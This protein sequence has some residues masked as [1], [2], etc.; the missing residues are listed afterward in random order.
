MRGVFAWCTPGSP[1]GATTSS[2]HTP[3][4]GRGPTT[5]KIA[6]RT[7]HHVRVGT[8]HKVGSKR[9]HH[10]IRRLW[11]IIAPQMHSLLGMCSQMRRKVVRATERLVTAGIIAH[12]RTL[13]GMHQH[14]SLQVLKPFEAPSTGWKLAR[15]LV[16]LCSTAVI[17]VVHGRYTGLTGIGGNRIVAMLHIAAI[18]A[19]V[20]HGHGACVGG[21]AHHHHRWILNAMET[22]ARATIVT[23]V[24][25]LLLQVL[26]V[27]SLMVHV[28]HMVVVVAVHIGAVF[29][30]AKWM[31]GS[32]DRRMMVMLMSIGRSTSKVRRVGFVVM[33]MVTAASPAGTRSWLCRMII[34]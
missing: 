19:H 22:I 29:K 31:V 7:S 27:G 34:G 26:W 3:I 5:R 11:A 32:M 13:F 9:V 2:D 21:V 24:G 16:A 15:M 20:A 25:V 30:I 10:H 1:T 12:K 17:V 33:M 28:L 4:V 23:I 14:V 8:I 18:M 6:K